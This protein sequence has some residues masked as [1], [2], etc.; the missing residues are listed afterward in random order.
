MTESPLLTELIQALRCLPGVGA[1]SAQRMAYHMLTRDR[2]NARK[3]ATIMTQAMDNIGRCSRCRTFSE[4]QICQLCTSSRRDRYQ[5]CVV[6]NP[7]DIAV[8]EQADYHGLYFVLMGLLS[9]LEGIGPEDIGL[10]QLTQRIKEGDAEELI[11]AISTTIEG[12]ATAH[13]I[14]EIAKKHKLTATRI[15]HGIPVGGSLEYVNNRT[16]SYAIAGRREI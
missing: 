6:E 3:L 12:D 16:I 5:L 14:G 9:P 13:F 1:K 11:I 7:A 4:A 10:P 8:I 15:A 2:D